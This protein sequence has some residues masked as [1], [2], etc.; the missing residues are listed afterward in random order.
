MSEHHK[1]VVK[2]FSDGK[3]YDVHWNPTTSK[4]LQHCVKSDGAYVVVRKTEREI[5]LQ[6]R[7]A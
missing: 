4:V 5:C 1:I 7:I 3:F 6:H 2:V